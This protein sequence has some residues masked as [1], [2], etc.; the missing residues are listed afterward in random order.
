MIHGNYLRHMFFLKYFNLKISDPYYKH[1]SKLF[2]EF[3]KTSCELH[4]PIVI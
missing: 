1:I 4:S 3:I 2:P